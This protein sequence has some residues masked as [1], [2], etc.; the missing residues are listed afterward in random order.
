MSLPCK[1][2]H[3][4][5]S[6]HDIDVILDG[7][8]AI[9]RLSRNSGDIKMTHHVEGSIIMT[10]HRNMDEPVMFPQ[11]T[12]WSTNMESGERRRDYHVEQ[13]RCNDKAYVKEE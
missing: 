9:G 5:I 10:N 8:P 13:E 3:K 6:R 12:V 11:W 7:L 1:M 2:K 4:K